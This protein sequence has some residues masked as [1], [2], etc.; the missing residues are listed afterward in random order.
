MIKKFLW[1]NFLF[2]FQTQLFSTYYIGAVIPY[3]FY[4]G[5][6]FLIL[7]PLTTE[8]TTLKM[9]KKNLTFCE[10]FNA[11]KEV[12]G[13]DELLD[14]D[15]ESLLYWP[16]AQEAFSNKFLHAFDYPFDPIML[17]SENTSANLQYHELNYMLFFNEIINENDISFCMSLKDINTQKIRIV[18]LNT[19]INRVKYVRKRYSTTLGKSPS[20]EEEDEIPTFEKYTLKKMEEFKKQINQQ[21]YPVLFNEFLMS[22]NPK[23]T[24]I[25]EDI[26]N[27]LNK[28]Q[29]IILKPNLITISSEFK[30]QEEKAQ[31]KG[32]MIDKIRKS[33]KL[34][35]KKSNNQFQRSLSDTIT[36][37]MAPDETVPLLRRPAS[38]KMI[39]FKVQKELGKKLKEREK[40]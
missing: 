10:S 7:M 3:F 18:S 28:K 15:A 33:L 25:I 19:I 37:F 11:G 1:F 24:E 2:F 27:D 26:F 35:W 9:G 36:P 30:E 29:T 5:V 40:E 21:E 14:E 20:F 39:E 13:K 38:E 12:D 34:H 6:C 4:Q 17:A 32:S 16:L 22:P 8:V 23:M 31:Q